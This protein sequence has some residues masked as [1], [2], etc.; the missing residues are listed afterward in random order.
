MVSRYL[1][2]PDTARASVVVCLICSKAFLFF[3]SASLHQQSFLGGEQRAAATNLE[4]PQQHR[5]QQ[6]QPIRV[7][8]FEFDYKKQRRNEMQRQAKNESDNVQRSRW[9]KI[10]PI[11]H[12]S[13]ELDREIEQDDVSRGR[14][15]ID[16]LNGNCK[17]S[18]SLRNDCS[19][20]L[21][22]VTRSLQDLIIDKTPIEEKDV[23][24]RKDFPKPSQSISSSLNSIP[25]NLN[26][27]EEEGPFSKTIT[28]E[29]N[30]SLNKRNGISSSNIHSNLKSPRTPLDAIHNF[31]TPKSA[32]STANRAK[33][34]RKNLYK[35][36]KANGHLKGETCFSSIDGSDN[37]I[38]TCDSFVN[39]QMA[40][41][42]KNHKSS[43]RSMQCSESYE[44]VKFS[45]TNRK[46]LPSNNKISVS[47]S[48][49]T[50]SQ[51]AEASKSSKPSQ[52]PVQQRDDRIIRN[53]VLEGTKND[54][55]EAVKRR[56]KSN[57]QSE[58]KS[59]NW[60][61]RYSCVPQYSTKKMSDSNDVGR[62]KSSTRKYNSS[63]EL[64]EEKQTAIVLAK[65]KRFSLYHTPQL[66][67]KAYEE[68][69]VEKTKSVET[70]NNKCVTTKNLVKKKEDVSTSCEKREIKIR[71][72]VV[73]S[74]TAASRNKVN[75]Q[76]VY[77]R[78]NAI[79]STR[80]K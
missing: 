7:A 17:E 39:V 50:R 78:S 13:A 67:R 33:L 42:K 30:S 40:T 56:I 69:K 6:R 46:E 41:I 25:E 43:P 14:D 35:V 21:S 65:A 64:R 38:E 11:T 36:A 70:T 9:T 8:T 53:K 71:K 3:F 80:T 12:K 49:Q 28:P 77:N 57:N 16:F 37:E 18:I 32:K 51:T 22:T 4:S 48:R 31:E 47:S 52:I 10:E 76:S 62:S 27:P 1:G 55:N 15:E 63:D 24:Y 2:H 23:S 19:K 34:T 61:K 72:S 75:R 59:D 58:L 60:S 20:D 79:N 66:T 68:T 74:S 45:P 44:N 73:E 26:S 29:K 5:D 54:Q